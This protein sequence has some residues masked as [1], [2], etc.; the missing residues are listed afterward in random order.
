MVLGLCV[1]PNIRR[2]MKPQIGKSSFQV[3]KSLL[4]EY[5]HTSGVASAFRVPRLIPAIYRYR[6]KYRKVHRNETRQNFRPNK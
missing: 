1:L 6:L 2:L 5:T 4:R 3:L